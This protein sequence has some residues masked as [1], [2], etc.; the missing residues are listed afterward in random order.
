[1]T[2]AC[3]VR[4]G[5][6]ATASLIALLRR[7]HLLWVIRIA[8]LYFMRRE[9]CYHSAPL[10]IVQKLRAYSTNSRFANLEAGTRRTALILEIGQ[11]LCDRSG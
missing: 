9:V 10:R 8:F 3:M 1:M 11:S 4:G 6:R 5:A 7:I 2:L